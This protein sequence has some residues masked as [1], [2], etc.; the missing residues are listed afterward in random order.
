MNPAFNTRSGYPVTLILVMLFLLSACNA[1]SPA[2]SFY[3]LSPLNPKNSKP[4]SPLTTREPCIGLGPVTLPKY[5]AGSKIVTRLSPNRLTV[6]EL[7]RWGGSL[8]SEITRTLSTN[9]TA[10]TGITQIISYPWR[11]NQ[12]PDYQLNI[13]FRSFDA[14][15]GKSVEL[16]A[17]W[18]LTSNKNPEKC[19]TRVSRISEQIS[20]TEIEN[21]VAAESRAIESLS[22][23]I[24]QAMAEIQ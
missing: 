6:N 5:L 10:L 7:H 22:I 16:V 15:P 8:K 23:Q 24:A 14:T 1:S 21:I 3:T 9:L 13:T 17:A 2:V 20:S 4:V 18:T 11:S 12:A 19:L